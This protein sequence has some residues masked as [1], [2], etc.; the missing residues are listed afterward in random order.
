ML[1]LSQLITIQHYAV[2]KY[3]FLTPAQEKHHAVVTM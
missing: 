3:S 2:L 1:F